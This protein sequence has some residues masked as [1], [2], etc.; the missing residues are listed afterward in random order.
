MDVP[1][2][3]AEDTVL[4][5]FVRS[6]L[7]V[8]SPVSVAEEASRATRRRF[9]A[10]MLRTGAGRRRAESYFWGIV[11]RRALA[12]RAPA[13]ARLIVAASLAS[14]LAEAGHRPEAVA[15]ALI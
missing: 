1:T 13:V 3:R 9:T 6:A 4:D 2:V 14:E 12:G 11:R 7:L 15:R 5:S 10:R 8:G